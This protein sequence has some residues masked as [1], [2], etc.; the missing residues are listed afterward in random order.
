MS[1]KQYM[2]TLSE[3]MNHLKEK[4]YTEDFSIK[5]NSV[6]SSSGKSYKPEE[7]L[8]TETYRFEG[9]SNPSDSSELFAIEATDGVKGLLV[10]AFGAMTEVNDVVLKKIK[11]K[12]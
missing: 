10:S 5:E 1:E 7:L 11:F 8:I 9:E 4:G 12:E 6:S 3:Q 2:D